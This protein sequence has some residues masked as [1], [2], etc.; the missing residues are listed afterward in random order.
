ML[1]VRRNGSVAGRDREAGERAQI[2]D[3]LPHVVGAGIQPRAH[4]G[5]P[6]VEFPQLAGCLLHIVDP[7]RRHAA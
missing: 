2:G 4:C 3:R 5:S 6:E 1:C 7:A